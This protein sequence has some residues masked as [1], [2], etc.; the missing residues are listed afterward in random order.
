MLWPNVPG[1]SGTAIAASYV[2]TSAPKL[3]RSAVVA[4]SSHATTLGQLTVD[5]AVDGVPMGALAMN[6]AGATN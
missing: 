4:T 6:G 2:V 1:Q 3:S 5:R